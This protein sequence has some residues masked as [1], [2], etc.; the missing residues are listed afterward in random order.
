M[1]L[2]FAPDGFN[3][4]ESPVQFLCIGGLHKNPLPYYTTAASMCSSSGSPVA[5]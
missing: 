5:L 3:R 2:A 4:V 1:G